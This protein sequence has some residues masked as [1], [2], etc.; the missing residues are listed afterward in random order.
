MAVRE[1]QIKLMDASATQSLGEAIGR[2]LTGGEFVAL[3]GPLGAGKTQLVKGIALGLAVSGEQ[4]IVS[5]TFVLVR[6]YAGRLRLLH[7]DAYRLNSAEEWRALGVEEHRTNEA[8]VALEWAD[9]LAGIVPEDA[10]RIDLEYFEAGRLARIVGS[11]MLIARLGRFDASR[12]SSRPTD[13]NPE[14]ATPPPPAS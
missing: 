10:I 13:P 3:C 11:E 6:E 9:R 12:S 7:A 5:P 8:V 14:S 2:E 4:P 1:I